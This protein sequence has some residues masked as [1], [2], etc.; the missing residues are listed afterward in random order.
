MKT[1]QTTLE[2]STHVIL[3]SVT[4]VSTSKSERNLPR[5]S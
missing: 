2:A 5:L 4:L 1:L 3:T